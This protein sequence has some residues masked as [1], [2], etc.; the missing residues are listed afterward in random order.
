MKKPVIS[1]DKSAQKET[2]EML[3]I[4]SSEGGWLIKDGSPIFAFDDGNPIHE[5]EF[6]GVW[7]G[8]NGQIIYFKS[9][10]PS[11]I[12][13]LDKINKEEKSKGVI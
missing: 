9:D 13:A 11:L 3:G 5:S 10:L 6:G 12:N 8:K 2:L 1:F 7:K 4:Y